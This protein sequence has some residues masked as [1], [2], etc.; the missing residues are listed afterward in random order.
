MHV[1]MLVEAQPENFEEFE[2]WVSSFAFERS[3]AEKEKLIKA[4]MADTRKEFIDKAIPLVREMR[5]YNVVI[6]EDNKEEFLGVMKNVHSTAQHDMKK[7]D[8]AVKLLSMALPIDKIDMEKVKNI[9]VHKPRKAI[10][11]YILCS[12]KDIKDKDGVE[13]T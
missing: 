11:A 8:T 9:P 10:Y 5:M 2:S 3:D 13:M 1:F 7:V 6:P 4:G 12:L